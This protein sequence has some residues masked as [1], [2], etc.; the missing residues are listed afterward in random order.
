V[1]APGK[2]ALADGC[3]DGE[4]WASTSDAFLKKLFGELASLGRCRVAARR[5]CA[6][7]DLDRRLHPADTALLVK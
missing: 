4:C 1:F 3:C 2:V 7:M 5:S 6:V